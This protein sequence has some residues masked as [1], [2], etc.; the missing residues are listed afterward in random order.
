MNIFMKLKRFV[1]KGAVNQEKMKIE[2]RTLVFTIVGAFGI[3]GVANQPDII[4]AIF[5]PLIG[6]YAGYCYSQQFF[7]RK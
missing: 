6:G 3:L 4:Q 7:R 1:I 5:L 2:L